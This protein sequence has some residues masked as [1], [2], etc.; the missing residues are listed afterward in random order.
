MDKTIFR[1]YDI[2][3]KSGEQ[4]SNDVMY[5]LGRALGTFLTSK[6]IKTM[7]VARDGRV[8]GPDFH[9]ALSQGLMDSGINVIDRGLCT[10]P[11]LYFSCATTKTTSGVIITGSHN[12]PED[13]GLKIVVN[14]RSLLQEELL[15]LYQIIEKEAFIN[16]KASLKQQTLYQNYIDDIKQ[17]IQTGK[18]L[19]VV[20]DSGNGAA[21]IIASDVYAALGFEVIA[22]YDE[23]DGTFPNHQPDPSVPKNLI[24]LQHAVLK[25]Q[26]DIGLAFDGDG[27]RVGVVDEKGQSL[28][29]DKLLMLLAEDLLAKRKG[30]SIVYDIKCTN[31]LPKL[32]S[33]K[34]GKPV[35]SPTGHSLVKAKMKAISAEL[36]G[37]MSGHIFYQ[38]RWYGFDDGVYTGARVLEILSL[39]K[40]PLSEIMHQYPSLVSTP[41]IKIA[42]TAK[43]KFA[44]IEQLKTA[45]NDE[46][47]AK[48]TTIDGVRIDYDFGW[49]LVRASNTTEN[50]T[51]RFEAM[52]EKFLNRLMNH[53]EKALLVISPTL[54][55]QKKT[56][57]FL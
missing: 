47:D 1:A 3:G 23:I 25:H 26:A 57:A 40:A 34:G 16:G 49:A 12:P 35:L 28:F 22:L 48:V 52:D 18:K 31:L 6:D 44:I 41:E 5:T 10:S 50:L 24:D 32:I 2:R 15:A 17:K 42:V 27:D 38:D 14:G 36:A 30:A 9:Q 7:N 29:A 19:K 20:I 33:E 55:F 4:L 56:K 21:A 13:N 46:Q 43:E 53:M 45:F 8:T 54:S 39:A 37:E 11:L 51:L